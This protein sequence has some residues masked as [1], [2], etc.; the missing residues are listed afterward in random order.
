MEF[1]SVTELFHSLESRKQITSKCFNGIKFTIL[2]L[3]FHGL[4]TETEQWYTFRRHKIK[5]SSHFWVDLFLFCQCKNILLL[6]F[7]N[8]TFLF[9]TSLSNSWHIHADRKMVWMK[10]ITGYFGASRVRPGHRFPPTELPWVSRRPT[11]GW[12]DFVRRYLDTPRSPAH[13]ARIANDIY[14][15]QQELPPMDR[16]F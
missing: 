1:V 14:G 12:T 13:Q 4:Y 6:R 11:T 7:F 10:S 9:T 15:Q 3:G 5:L 16:Y 2:F 8:Y